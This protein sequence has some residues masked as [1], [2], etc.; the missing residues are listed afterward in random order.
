MIH[1]RK[2]LF[3]LLL[4][5]LPLMAEDK[6]TDM[7]LSPSLAG[8]CIIPQGVF[9]EMAE[10]GFGL[11]INFGLTHLFFKN[12]IILLSGGLNFIN[13]EREN[14]ES[15]W[16]PYLTVLAGYDFP[17]TDNFKIT[18][19]VG[20]GYL[21]HIIRGSSN[22]IDLSL[23]SYLDPLLTIQCAF[24]VS[25]YKSFNLILTPGYTF[26][27]EEH[28]TGK[29][30]NI[31]LGVAMD[32][33]LKRKTKPKSGIPLQPTDILNLT[34]QP[35]SPDNDGVDDELLIGIKV[36]DPDSVSVWSIR[37]VDP[38]GIPFASFDG[39]GRP[40]EC[41]IWNGISSG[42][43]LVQSAEDYLLNLEISNTQG[44]IARIN[45]NIS[46]DVLVIREGDRLKIRIS[47]ITFPPDSP[48]LEAVGDKEKA[49]RN[50]KTLK[51]LVEIFQKYRD[52]SIRIDGH[53]NNL[54]WDDPVKASEEE[55][56]ELIPL[57]RE[58][59]LAVK[60]ALVKL[61]LDSE[62]ISIVGSGGKYPIVPFR[63]TVNR[64]KNRRVEFILIKS[65]L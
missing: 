6:H 25:L 65:E 16:M 52:Y 48:D 2:I 50:N 19:A 62:R 56:E 5:T 24:N 14:I 51:R 26:F 61:G 38:R 32:F 53:A 41:I 30:F 47:S 43:E 36:D 21:L 13:E 10:P 29:Y 23:E 54:F 57:S 18:P 8:T 55:I 33:H 22:G 35:F 31:G 58:R 49:N 20:C 37:I 28:N 11:A 63:D 45:K 34:P 15:F 40:P 42:G 3:P 7:I 46:V 39:K 27:F 12:S 59:A 60:E 44:N 64:W 9:K 1:I 17:L 4:F